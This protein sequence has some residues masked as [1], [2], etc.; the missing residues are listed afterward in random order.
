MAKRKTKQGRDANGK[1][2]SAKPA[3]PA[4]EL[5]KNEPKHD[6][7]GK[8]TSAKPAEPAIDQVKKP[9]ARKRVNKEFAVWLKGSGPTKWKWDLPHQRYICEKLDKVTS[10]ETKRMM[11]FMP[12]RH[13]KSE[14]VTIRYA[15]WRIA[16]DPKLNIILASYNQKLAN[17]FSRR[18]RR[19]VE[20]YVPMADDRKAADEWETMAGGGMR[21][22][23]VGGG[24]TGF[25]AGLVII[26][27]P[28][29]NRAE[30]ESR[31][32]R[33]NASLWFN[34]DIY[35]RLEPE[36]PIILIQTRWH[37]DDLA[38][39]LIREMDE[40]ETWDV[41]NLPALAEADDPLGRPPGEPLW[42]ERFSAARL[43]ATHRRQGSYSFE[44]LYQQ[45]PIPRSGGLFKREWFTRIVERAPAG[46]TWARGYDLA[47][48]QD[49]RADY[50]AS[51]RCAFG[52]GGI[53][54]IADGFRQRLTYT[55]QR[56]FI[57]ERIASEPKTLHGVESALHGQALVQDL[58]A[59]GACRGKPLRS[60][61]VTEDK[62]TR[63]HTWAP[64]AEVGSVVLVE[65]S[66]IKEFVDEACAFPAS[67]HDDQVDAV[68][69]AVSMLAARDRKFLR[70]F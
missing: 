48:S 29:K 57:A 33:D 53:L 36:A 7:K 56:K 4:N 14:L 63:A 43:A 9:V 42:P 35:T 6:A 67:P 18:V 21:A 10:G 23:G 24:I 64:I 45:R 37:E 46:L 17:R 49:T 2:T 26:D 61:R 34:D 32:R 8:F 3:E 60:V 19:L 52:P 25:G 70:T 66:W 16:R 40:G 47:I 28:V 62:W 5:E 22:V 65:G 38:G 51:F 54:Y 68:S 27:D 69:L 13:G 1:F 59:S 55:Q 58:I 30:A 15:A 31:V 20:Q 44:A 12:P 50:T 41:I 39:R 11:V